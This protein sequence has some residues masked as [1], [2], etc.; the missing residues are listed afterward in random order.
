MKN[1]I[2]L[3]CMLSY[4]SLIGRINAQGVRV[5]TFLG[6]EAPVLDVFWISPFKENSSLLFLNRNKF[7]LPMYKTG[8]ES[9]SILNILSYN[10]KKTGIGPA[11]AA[12]SAS[13]SQFQFRSGLQFLKISP[14]NWLLYSIISTKLGN[15]SDARWLFI[16]QFTPKFSKKIS[17]LNRLEWVSSIGYSD[18]H[19][20][21]QLDY[22]IGIQ[23]NKWEM[24]PA[25]N[26]F[27]TGKNFLVNSENYGVF[28]AHYF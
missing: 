17:M 7:L 13:N 25:L 3:F 12:T 16:G 2:L 24:G 1:K 8:S 10:V 20:F 4:L 11:L 21:S 22:R 14:S 18:G 15:H 23:F 5:E 6:S 19:R 27:W 26:I 9:Y 28:F